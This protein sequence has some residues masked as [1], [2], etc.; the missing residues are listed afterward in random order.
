M[1]NTRANI[2]VVD[3]EPGLRTVLKRTLESREFS[4]RT[5][6]S[7]SEALLIVAEDEPDVV[8]SDIR[9][10]GGDGTLLL[11][12]LQRTNPAFL[13]S[14]IRWMRLHIHDPTDLPKQ[15]RLPLRR[16]R[17]VLKGSL[18]PEFYR[19]CFSLELS[20]SRSLQI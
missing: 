19:R 9:M 18:T 20:E 4:C 7:V 2:L 17:N 6:S 1:H 8:V 10:P 15:L 14:W 3:D 5:A 16:L 12:E 11:K 13:P